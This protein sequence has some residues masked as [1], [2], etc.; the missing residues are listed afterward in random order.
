MS[1]RNVPEIKQADLFSS[2]KQASPD[3]SVRETVDR[4]SPT[5]DAPTAPALERSKISPSGSGKTSAGTSNSA[6]PSPKSEQYSGAGGP[7]RFLTVKQ[8]SA[9][10]GVA[11]STIWRWS[12]EL[13]DF[14]KPVRLGSGATR[15]VLEE[16][17]AY[18]A[19]LRRTK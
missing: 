4:I 10:Y 15:W 14:P 7:G 19:E 9:R 3:L 17:L 18:E 6:K 16:L 11:S 2:A 5:N 1:H 12:D 13:P 8:V